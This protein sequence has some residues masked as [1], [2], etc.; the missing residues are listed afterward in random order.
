MGREQHDAVSET[1]EPLDEWVH[2]QPSIDEDRKGKIYLPVNVEGARLQRC[3]VLAAGS[4]VGDLAPGDAV[5]VLASQAIDLRDGTRL[6][7]RES[8][9]AR[10]Q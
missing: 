5:L 1:L 2:L 9:V 6:A 7:Q 3:V 4:Q 8:I 10:L